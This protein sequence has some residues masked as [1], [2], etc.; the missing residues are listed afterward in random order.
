MK[1]KHSKEEL[2]DAVKNSLSIAGVCRIL[3]IRPIGGNYKTLK[4]KFKK[5]KIN[6]DHFTGA[7]WN[8]GDRY[9][10]INPKKD[11]SEILTKDSGFMSGYYLKQRLFKEGVKD[12]Y[13]EKCS[14][15]KWMDQDI[16]LELNHKNGDNMDHRLENLEILCPNCH[17]QTENYRGKAK[18]SNREEKRKSLVEKTP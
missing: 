4:S 7:G 8:T 15:T 3:G 9:R 6:T 17:A 11:L 14:N 1:Y 13:C 10:P 2:Q 16:H 12:K 5:F 18:K